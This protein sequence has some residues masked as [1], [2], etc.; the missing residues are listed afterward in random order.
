MADSQYVIDIAANMPEAGVTTAQLDELTA[1]LLEA[2]ASAETLDAAT[3]QVNRSLAAAKSATEAANAALAEGNARYTELERAAVNAAKAAERAASQGKLDPM[4]SKTAYEA[5]QAL[6]AEAKALAKLESEAFAASKS[7]AHLV[8]TQGNLRKISSAASSAFAE[9]AAAAKK[10]VREAEGMVPLVKQYNDFSDAVSTSEGRMIIATGAAIGVATAVAAITAAAVA[11]TLAVAGW[12]AG[13]ANAKRDA[14]LV[15]EAAAALLPNVREFGGLMNSLSD[16]TGVGTAELRGFAKQLEGAKVKAEDMPSALRAV[17]LSSAALG[18]E[19][20]SEFFDRL[21]EAKGAVNDLSDEVNSQLGGIVA[22]R[23]MGLTQQSAKLKKNFNDLFSGLNIEP[24]LEGMRVLVDLFDKNTAAGEAMKFLFE[25]VFQPLIDQATNAAYI[26]EAFVLGFLIG[27]TKLYV[28]L[29]PA[30]KAIGEF[31]GFD[32]TSLESVLSLV[33]KAGEYAAYIFVGFAAVFGV[34]AVAI[35][36]VVAQFVVIQ[37]AIYGLIAAVVYAGAQIVSGFLSAWQSVKDYLSNLS[38]AEIGTM[39]MRGLA[40]GVTAGATE[41]IN[42]IISVASSAIGAAKKALGIASPSK[43]FA[44]IGGFTAEGFAQGVD[45]GTA[46]AQAAMTA[47]VEAPAPGEIAPA[48]YS[49]LSG[50]YA[51]DSAGGVSAGPSRAVNVYGDI[52]FGGS[53][54]TEAE[55]QNLAEELTKLLEADAASVAG[56]AA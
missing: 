31:F 50:G 7:Q 32:D 40:A 8:Q 28:A 1:S 56:E 10:S 35:A 37:V 22:R 14:D 24:V 9:Q 15:N 17:A 55:K 12:A 20:V 45:D 6:A 2:G 19:G 3:I 26:V 23:M 21:K 46:N 43:V 54:A 42:A 38:L 25:E 52:Y 39:L 44:D 4:L 33:T 29:K 48:G 51:G 13:L 30:I 47:M 5:E 53:K 16:E 36:A 41:V 18:Q 27:L 49:A 11:G 34:V